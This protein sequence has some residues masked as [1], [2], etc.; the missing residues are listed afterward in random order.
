MDRNRYSE[1]QA[2]LETKVVE[3]SQALHDRHAIA[4][5]RLPDAFDEHR[6]AADREVLAQTLESATSLLR[7]VRAALKRMQSGH[8]GSCAACEEEISVKRLRA[9]P[10]ALYCVH[11]QAE[12]DN[13]ESE[14]FSRAA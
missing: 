3:L 4:V 14:S 7:Q 11:C 5:E 2:I 13:D 10:W 8:Y 12:L 6:L 1:F 9:L